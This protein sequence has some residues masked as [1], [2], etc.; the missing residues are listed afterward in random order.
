MVSEKSIVYEDESLIVVNKP[1]GILTVP[2]P[3]NEKYTLTACLNKVLEKR[4]LN[5]KVFPCHRLDRETSG[6]IIYAKSPAA[7]EM[8]M[9]QFKIGQVKKKY[10]AFVQGL[11][12]NPS[13]T[14]SFP[15]ENKKAITKYKL[16]QRRKDY[17]IIEVEPSTGRTNQIRIHFKMIGH[18][19]L[20]ERKFA[21]G[22][23]SKVK[24]RRVALHASEIQFRHPADG[25][26]LCFSSKLADDMNRLI[27]SLPH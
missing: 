5:T 10:I 12:K 6:L 16:L 23:D 3:K 2:T 20:G 21:F 25:R 13:D 24:F 8:I 19:L 11:I 4:G 9:E 17:S 15:I 1:S 14:I 22:K 7:Q 27:G 18:P 26:I